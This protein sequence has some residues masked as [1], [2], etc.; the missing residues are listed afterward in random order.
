MT[1]VR[2]IICRSIADRSTAFIADE[3]WVEVRKHDRGISIASIYR[4]LTDLVQ[5]GLLREIHG[6]RDERA[7]V[8]SASTAAT[9]GHLICKDCHRIV[10]LSD[11]CLALREGAM[12]RGL[13]FETGG[14]HLQIEA[15]CESL[16]RCGT[17]ENH[18][19]PPP[20]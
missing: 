18:D 16:K 17:C 13:G 6:P 5:A 11:D 8:K 20:R 9:S 19:D 1:V 3:L 10:P 7:F 14:M 15:A 4:T 12:I 2:E